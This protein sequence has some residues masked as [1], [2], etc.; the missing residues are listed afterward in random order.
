MRRT[1]ER[2]TD[3]L[4]GRRDRQ[5]GELAPQL[6]DR[7]VALELDLGAG[8]FEERVSLGLGRRPRFLMDP[9]R[10]LLR[11]LDDCLPLASGC[12]ELLLRGRA[13]LELALSALLGGL[14]ALLDLPSPLI[15]D[16]EHRLVEEGAQE[17]EQD[18]EAQDLPY[19]RR[20]VYAEVRYSKNNHSDVRSF[21]EGLSRKRSRS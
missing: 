11:L 3:D 12:V 15:E 14:K 6:R 13:G 17:Q 20:Y 10:H 7:I 2:L 9:L 1:I 8:S 4:L 5:V 18:R 19:Q 21:R 16:G